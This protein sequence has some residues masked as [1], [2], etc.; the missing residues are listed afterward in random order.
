MARTEL[1]VFLDFVLSS[2][3]N[4][5]RQPGVQKKSA[6]FKKLSFNSSVEVLERMLGWVLDF[7]ACPNSAPSG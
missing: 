3:Y 1:F 2:K 7:A 6:S 5:L 4:N